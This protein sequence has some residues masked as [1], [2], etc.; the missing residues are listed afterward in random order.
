MED[1]VT[2]VFA[3]DIAATPVT[4]PDLRPEMTLQSTGR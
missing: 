3:P 1:A 2:T 4:K